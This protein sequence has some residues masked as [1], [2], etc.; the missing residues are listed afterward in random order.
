M[1]DFDDIINGFEGKHILVLG[2]IMLDH[3]K[4]GKLTRIS[5]EAAVPVFSEERENY[6]LGGSGNVAANVAELGGEVTIIGVSGDDK[7]SEILNFELKNKNINNEI[8][9]DSNRL[10]T[11]KTRFID[12]EHN[13]QVLRTDSETIKLISSEL[14][15][16]IIKKVESHL[17]KATKIIIL[18][19]YKKGVL[20]QRIVKQIIE[21]ANKYGA[22]TVI[23]PKP[24]TIKYCKNS[25][26]ITPN[27]KEASGYAGIEE[28]NGEEII[29][30][31]E[32]LVSEL[33]SNIL[34]TRGSKGM[35]LFEK[36]KEPYM[37]KTVAKQ[38]YDVTGAGDT[39]TALISLCL[40]TGASLENSI[41]IANIGAGL[42]VAKTGTATI[43]KKELNAAL[44]K[45]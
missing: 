30:I 10:T 16:E 27:H 31:G 6:K 19:D 39:V 22:K 17:S 5:P 42:V 40:A 1:K 43:S 38:V 9:K 36:N 44:K 13:Q 15:E 29:L 11:R 8:I 33:N 3:Y 12:S 45:I 25:F 34:I 14:E 4:F 2:D 21:L 28:N 35:A 23:D 24:E 26:I 7:E 20:T 18:S 41:N 37:L 32:K